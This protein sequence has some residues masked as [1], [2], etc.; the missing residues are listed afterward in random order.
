[1][2]FTLSNVFGVTV[3]DYGGLGIKKKKKLVFV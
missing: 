1:M 3:H 2:V